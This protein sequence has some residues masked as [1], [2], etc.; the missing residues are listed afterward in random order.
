MIYRENWWGYTTRR[1]ERVCDRAVWLAYR[2]KVQRPWLRWLTRWRLERLL[3]WIGA[4]GG[5]ECKPL[6]DESVREP[7]TK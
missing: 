2:D 3:L 4:V 7:A 5:R 6:P 1:Y